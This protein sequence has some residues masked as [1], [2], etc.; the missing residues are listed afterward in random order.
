MKKIL[1]TLNIGEYN[2]NI[3]DLTYPYIKK[4]AE[5]IGAEF[6]VISERK[7][8]DFP[9]TYEKLQIHTL[10]RE[11][12]ADWSIFVDSDVLIHPD[13]FD[14]TEFLNKDTVLQTRSDLANNRFAY[15]EFFRRDGRHIGATGWFSVASSWCNDF[16]SPLSDISLEEA[17]KNIRPIQAEKNLGSKS[18]HFIDDYVTSRN[19]AKYGLKFKNLDVLI[20]EQG[21]MQTTESYLFHNH[22]ISEQEKV[23]LLKRVITN[24][25]I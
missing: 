18:D 13:M 9:I 4:Y 21:H 2:S 24:W 1:F 7:F 25:K 20:K 10:S 14:I 22:L 11:L 17:V 5:K 19:I 23:E 16:W 12:K 6:V 15:D 3:T 8:P